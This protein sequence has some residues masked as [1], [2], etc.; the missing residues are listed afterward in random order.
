MDMLKILNANFEAKD[1][2][3]LYYLHEEN[4]FHEITFS[5]LCGC[6]S[7]L[8]YTYPH[9]KVVSAQIIFIYGQVLRHI[10]YHF[11]S[12]DLSQISN[13]PCDYNKK[14]ETLE[15]IIIKYFEGS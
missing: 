11:D 14:L 5:E 10:I 1:K 6:I 7:S 4:Y 15:C 3:F 2:S 12:N 8:C 9:D 13:L